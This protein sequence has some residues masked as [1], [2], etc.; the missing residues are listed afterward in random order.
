[1]NEKDAFEMISRVCGGVSLN[2]EGHKQIQGALA[3]VSKALFQKEVT[4]TEEE[5]KNV[6]A[7]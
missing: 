4:E 3:I 7:G 6:G 5:K 1:M 2:L